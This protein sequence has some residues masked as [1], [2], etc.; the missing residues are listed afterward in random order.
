MSLSLSLAATIRISRNRRHRCL[1]HLRGGANEG[2]RVDLRGLRAGGQQ[3]PD[4]VHC[5]KLLLVRQ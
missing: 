3:T 5:Q 1:R 4:H 2:K